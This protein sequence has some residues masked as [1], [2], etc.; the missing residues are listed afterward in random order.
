MFAKGSKTQ[1]GNAN[2][3]KTLVGTEVDRCKTLKGIDKIHKKKDRKEKRHLIGLN[4]FAGCAS[5]FCPCF[6][7]R[8]WPLLL[9]VMPWNP[10]T[11][12]NFP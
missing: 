5:C 6:A 8:C 3:V 7:A 10:I 9:P 4:C 12:P 1:M 2:S 11:T